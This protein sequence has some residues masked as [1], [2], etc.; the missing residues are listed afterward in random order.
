MNGQR[1]A[2]FFWLGLAG[3]ENIKDAFDVVEPVCLRLRRQY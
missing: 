1:I 3:P 2:K